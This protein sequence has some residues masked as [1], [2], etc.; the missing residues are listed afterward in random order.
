M[1][2]TDRLLRLYTDLPV[3]VEVVDRRERFEMVLP[4]V[5]EMMDGGMITMERVTV[6]RYARKRGA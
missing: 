3:V 4:K 5:E 2:Q 6:R 1:Y